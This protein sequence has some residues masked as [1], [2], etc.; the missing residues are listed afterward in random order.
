MML[1]IQLPY[2]ET[3]AEFTEM[4][5]GVLMHHAITTVSTW[6]SVNG[7]CKL[8]PSNQPDSTILLQSTEDVMLIHVSKVIKD[9][10][11]IYDD[12]ARPSNRAA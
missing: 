5:G 11:A 7:R 8:N 4:E 1:L 6:F 9:I 2:R 3:N 10:I 12:M